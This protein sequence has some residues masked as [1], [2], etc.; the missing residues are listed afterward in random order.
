MRVSSTPRSPHPRHNRVAVWAL[1]ILLGTGVVSNTPAYGVSI[2][3]DRAT[4]RLLSVSVN[5]KHFDQVARILDSPE[6]GLLVS[7]AELKRW[8]LTSPPDIE[9]VQHND[10]VYFPLR[11]FDELEYSIDSANQALIVRVSA[12]QLAGS[13][14]DLDKA[15]ISMP[16]TATPGGFINYDLLH[17]IRA[18]VD[19]STSGTFELAGFNHWGLL[20]TTLL[21]RDNNQNRQDAGVV[22]L[23]S[24]LRHDDPS[25]LRTL[26]LGDT[27]SRPGAWG[28]G[29]LYGGIQWGTNFGTRPDFTT[30][31]L[32]NVSGEAIV[33]SSVEIYANDRRQTQNQVD[34]GPFSVRNIPVTTGANDLRLTVTDVLGREQ[35]IERSFYA[36][37]QLLRDGLHDYTYEIGA[38]REDYS[39]RSNQYGRG[40][41]SA[42]HRLGL[43]DRL[44]GELRLEALEDRQAAGLSGV[45][46]AHPRLGIVTG[47]I[48]GSSADAGDGGLASIGIERRGRHFSFG[49]NTTR[50]TADFR[51]LGLREDKP[52]PQWT[53]RANIG[54]RLPGSSAAGL[55]YVEIDRRDEADSRIASANYSISPSRN[56]TL[57]LYASQDLKSHDSFVGLTLSMSLG[58]RTSASISHSRDD[59]SYSNRVQLQRNTPRGNGVGYRVSAE[60]GHSE[61]NRGDAQITARTDV[62]TY[63]AEAAHYDGD[64]GYRFNATGGVVLLGG[65]VFATRRID[66]SFG[67]IKV[68]HYPDVTVY[69]E[70]QRVAT[71]NDNGAALIPD[72]RSFEKNR[73]GFEQAD[74]PLDARLDSRD[75]TVVPGFRRGVMVDFEVGSPD[76]ALLTVYQDNGEPLPAGA[77]IRH[78]GSDQ[79]FPVARRGEA[80][81]T[82]L[83]ADNQFVARWGEHS[84][85]FEASMPTN[86]GP[87]PRIGPLICQEKP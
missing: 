22:R 66:D 1:L 50:T 68:G 79:R 44:T 55:S 17:Q 53:T 76:G 56:A 84:C 32:P 28:R 52:A 4:P 85:R 61:P 8:G 2:T 36:S 83:K 11:R 73:L 13:R 41:A 72:L 24:T 40:F 45:W 9:A 12:R 71:T 25:K 75:A 67:M 65:N 87:M 15:E 14:I 57:G 49:A 46:L 10:K 47:S 16:Q 43:T 59:D 54:A 81:V 69:N 62:G 48:V 26:T 78:A 64:T 23:N 51:Q 21:A 82:G 42:T 19:D 80:W 18:D 3:A 77:T 29:V 60:P 38:I 34:A 58:A 70:N 33:P 5:G 35:V 39:Q 30:F 37:Q 6:Q 74:L 27:Y 31:P 7:R 20:T 86:P 63:R